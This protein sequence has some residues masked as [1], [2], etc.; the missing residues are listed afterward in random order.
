M[1]N[2]LYLIYIIGWFVLCFGLLTKEKLL[3]ALGSFVLLFAGLTTIQTGLGGTQNQTTEFFGMI[4]VAIGAS[5]LL[6][7]VLKEV[8]ELPI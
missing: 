3:Y 7:E 4:N 2:Y 6:K 5:L 1:L 8:E